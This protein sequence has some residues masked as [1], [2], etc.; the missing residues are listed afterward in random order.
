ML[1]FKKVL[2]F[3]VA[4]LIIFGFLN[5]I[6]PYTGLDKLYHEQ[7]IKVN[8]Y[9]YKDYKGTADVRFET[10]KVKLHKYNHSFSNFNDKVL[11]KI[12]S[13]KQIQ[14]ATQK[15]LRARPKQVQIN[16]NHAEFEIDTWRDCWIPLI[17]LMSLILATPVPI[18]RRLFALFLGVLAITGYT[19][20]RFWVRFVVDI[21]RHGWLELGTQGPFM[22]ST[23]V[24]MNTFLFY[25]G[26]SLIVT[27]FI[28]L[29]VT[30]RKGDHLRF[31]K[32]S[33]EGQVT[34]ENTNF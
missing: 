16:V 10:K 14:V 25:M 29:I 6:V 22:K 26:I 33:D 20:F 30:V 12:L 2:L 21:N 4:F 7:F 24:Y 19:L 11:V 32:E 5:F 17:L 27:V 8:Q 31:L 18:P 23:F 34:G 28:W 3:F 9:L 15:A 13:K 1:D